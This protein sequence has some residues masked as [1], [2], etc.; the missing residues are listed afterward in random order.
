MSFWKKKFGVK[1]EDPHTARRRALEMAENALTG[2]E[3]TIQIPA[4]GNPKC[5]LCGKT[6][7]MSAEQMRVLMSKSD[8]AV[9]MIK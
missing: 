3:A 7:H 4:S 2:V 8:A 9:H 1:K 6:H 5:P